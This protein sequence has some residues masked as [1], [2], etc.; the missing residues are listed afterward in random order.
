MKLKTNKESVSQGFEKESDY[1]TG[2]KSLLAK[3]RQGTSL[4]DSNNRKFSREKSEEDNSLGK[5]GT[6]LKR[7]QNLLRAIARTKARNL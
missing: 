6:K 3:S 2:R 1:L 7:Q 5:S 4:F